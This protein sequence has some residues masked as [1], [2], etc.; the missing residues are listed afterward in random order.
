MPDSVTHQLER[1]FDRLGRHHPQRRLLA[2]WANDPHLA[3]RTATDII[4]L[5]RERSL[6]QNPVVAALL[7]RHQDGDADAGT[8]LLTAMQPMVKRVI[9]L[10]HR[11]PLNTG[12]LDNYWAAASHLIGST[13]PTVEPVDRHG[14]PT[15]FISYLGDRLHHHLRRLDPEMRRHHDRVHTG[16]ISILP[17]GFRS[18]DRAAI[19]PDSHTSA[20]AVEDAAIAR[21][22]LTRVRTA[23][24]QGQITAER[25]QRLVEHRLGD[26]ATVRSSG[27]RVAVHRTGIRLADL[28][29]HA[30]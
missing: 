29:G 18:D 4:D 8:V 11:V 25:W 3:G 24:E 17:A 2:R 20:T 6:D 9:A 23:V 10:R 19:H 15:P 26:T 21:I 27:E 5:C 7:T 22:E 28:I 12:L 14:R 16:R 13:S 1:H 30:A